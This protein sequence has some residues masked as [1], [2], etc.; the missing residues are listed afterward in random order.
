MK[1]FQPMDA[2]HQNDLTGKGVNFG[3]AL[4]APKEGDWGVVIKDEYFP[5]IY[6]AGF[7]TV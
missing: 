4:E 3:N 6:S 7:S 1:P 5:L 2:N